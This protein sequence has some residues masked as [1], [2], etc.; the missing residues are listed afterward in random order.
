MPA[1]M[2]D[3]GFSVMQTSLKLV[4]TLHSL[5]SSGVTFSHN[6]RFWHFL[7]PL[8][9]KLVE[10]ASAFGAIR[11]LNENQLKCF[12]IT[13]YPQTAHASKTAKSEKGLI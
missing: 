8:H 2:S 9:T 11:I 3:L 12:E 5:S 10:L 6:W 4:P 7:R 13:S 1:K